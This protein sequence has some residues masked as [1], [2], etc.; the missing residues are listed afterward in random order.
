MAGW[1]GCGD[2]AFTAADIAG[3]G[4]AWPGAGFEG[5]LEEVDGPPFGDPMGSHRGDCQAGYGD[6]GDSR[7]P[8]VDDV[9]GRMVAAGS[10]AI[11]SR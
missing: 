11:Q 7:E 1:S 5:P 10:A 8:Q 3:T 9:H 6:G 2:A 4:G